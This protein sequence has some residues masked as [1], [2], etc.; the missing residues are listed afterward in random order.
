MTKTPI[1]ITTLEEYVNFDG[2]TDKHYELQDGVLVEMPSG[3]C[4]TVIT[5]MVQ[6]FY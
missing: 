2:G 4:Y 6:I 1:K 3:N 5:V